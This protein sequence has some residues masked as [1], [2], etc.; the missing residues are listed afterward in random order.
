VSDEPIGNRRR[1]DR[2]AC[3]GYAY[4]CIDEPLAI[5]VR[6]LRR[7]S[8]L[9]YAEVDVRCEWPGVVHHRGS[10][11]CAD[12][13]LSSQSARKA[14]AKYC[15]ERAHTKPA[16]FDWQGLIDAACLE[17]I[18]AERH[19]DDVIVLDDAPEVRELNFDVGGLQ[20]PADAASI[21]IA[22]GDSLKSLLLLYVLGTLAHRGVP[23]LYLDWEWSAARHRARKR[24]LFGEA[25][26]ERL[27]YQ[28]CH[29]PLVHEADRL[30]R[31]CDEHDIAFLA[32]DSIGLACDGKL[33]DDDVAIRFH[34][35]LGS[36]P[37]ALCA[38]HV[39]KSS[40]GPDGKGDAIGP[41][42]SVFFSNLC[43]ASW[44]VKK[45]EHD[46]HN[47][48]T[49]G[50]FRRKQN[51]GERTRPIGLQFTFHADG[52][53]DVKNVDLATVD[54]LAEKLPL[55]TRI[56]ALLKCKTMT[57]AELAEETGAK[58]DTVI[59]TVNRC[60]DLTKLSAEQGSR[61]RIALVERRI[62]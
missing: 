28:R 3:G 6:Y 31:Y 4:Q 49:V 9:L 52:G 21:L 56:K 16:D 25:R 39:P 36:L 8:G 13:N 46:T 15:G 24:R 59:K 58:L 14:L 7:A 23:V 10:L 55:I 5:E 45:Q 61:T 12:L 19:S 1:F 53:I 37:P 40:L 50:L 33:I 2:L 47:I 62:A 29:A 57:Y 60:E 44:L 18:R 51:D 30:T 48:V 20:V 43:R 26:L 54:G 27:H 34:R 42:G 11:S 38:A 22:H 41:F 35:A 17:V 32:V